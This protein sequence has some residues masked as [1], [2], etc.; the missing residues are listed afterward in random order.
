VAAS[1][2][3]C[4][5]GHCRYRRDILLGGGFELLVKKPRNQIVQMLQIR[6]AIQ[7]ECRMSDLSG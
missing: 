6:I 1:R 5:Y 2:L 3:A 4:S 7:I